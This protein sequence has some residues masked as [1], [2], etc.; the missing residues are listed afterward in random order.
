MRRGAPGRVL[1]VLLALAATPATAAGRADTPIRIYPTSPVP[2]CVTPERLGHFLLLR[3]PDLEPRLRDIAHWYRRHGEAW[4]VR[5]DY[6]FFQM[7][8]ETN[9]LTFRR[10]D[11]RMG[12]VHPRQNN[13]AGLG[14]TGNGTPGDSFPDVPTGVLAHIQ[15][16]VVYSGQRIAEPVAPRTRLKQADILAAL[17]RTAAHRPVTFQDLTGR[18]AIDRSYGRSIET[19]ADRFRELYCNGAPLEVA[20]AASLPAFARAAPPPAVR[21]Q[22]WAPALATKPQ[23]A[24]PP[25]ASIAGAC[26]VEAASF[27]GRKTLLIRTL[28]NGEE[29]FTALGVLEGFERSMAESFIRSHAPGGQPIAEFPSPEAALA[30]AF[31]LCPAARR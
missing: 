15:H 22:A 30:R 18:W 26:R 21:A 14:T 12:D 5:W 11:G 19:I 29:R 31:E 9:F 10:A 6:A 25:A 24:A 4:R 28:A 16:L 27:G 7:A 2:A 13:F 20:S 3:N 1:A 8:L 23:S 17:A